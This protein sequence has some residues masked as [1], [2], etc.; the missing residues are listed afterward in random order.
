MAQEQRQTFFQPVWAVAFLCP[1]IVIAFGEMSALGQD[2]TS[3]ATA[4]VTRSRTATASRSSR[5]RR[6]TEPVRIVSLPKAKTQGIVS[7]EQLLTEQA[8]VHQM[9]A[10][11][12]DNRVLSQL[13][14]AAQMHTDPA[15]VAQ[16]GS[17]RNNAPVDP[18]GSMQL[19]FVT[20]TGVYQYQPGAHQMQQVSSLDR[21]TDL[22]L[23]TVDLQAAGGVGCGI[24]ITGPVRGSN[25]RT[26][27]QL[28]RIALLETGRITQNIRLQA[29]ALKLVTASIETFDADRVKPVLNLSR[30][31]E[32]LY[33]LFVGQ[34]SVPSTL[35]PS[36]NLPARTKRV[37]LVVPPTGF[38]D[39]ELF[40]M[41]RLLG[42][43]GVETLVVSLHQGA[44]T[45]TLGQVGESKM[46]ITA[47][48]LE[49]I[50]ALVFIGGVGIATLASNPQVLTV[51]QRA[52]NQGRL[53]GATSTAPILLAKSGLLQGV[54]VTADPSEQAALQNAG[55]VYTGNAVE[56][57][58]TIL[59][60]RGASAMTTYARMM[61]NALADN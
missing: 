1:V 49:Q 35:D 53:I 60:A 48:P 47:L 51:V 21:R 34:R 5:S 30:S 16:I 9:T 61:A 57:D 22:V 38:N 26:T 55:A 6:Q 32:P 2:R 24:V 46:A 42:M 50:D 44:I 58:G 14:W 56:R 59:T 36:A 29:T 25:A 4:A 33:V 8:E 52:R 19:H 40:E 10:D 20:A 13:A 54:R 18:R 23:G 28:K 11:A 15:Q 17:R 37:A 31:L 45:S 7:L 27:V 12:L 43:A 3:T 41:Q 39:S